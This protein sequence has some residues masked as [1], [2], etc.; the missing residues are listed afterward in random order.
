MVFPGYATLIPHVAALLAYLVG[1]VIA[2]ILLVRA[3]GTAAILAVVGF[4]LLI[5]ISIGQ[6]VL[7]LPPVIRE[8]YRAMWAVWVLNCCCSLLDVAAVA[9]LIVAIW[10]AVSGT[11][12]GDVLYTDEPLEEEDVLDVFEETPQ[13]APSATVKLEDEPE[14]ALEGEI[15]EDTQAESPYTTKV[16]RETQ[17]EAEE[18]NE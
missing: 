11:G 15:L 5:L 1:L 16:L 10:Q 7:S 6:I 4:A 9:C 13:A 12:A 17:E 3:K 8:L 14:E 2:I 18:E